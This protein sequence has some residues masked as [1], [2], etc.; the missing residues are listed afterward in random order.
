MPGKDLSLR[1]KCIKAKTC[2]AVWVDH[3]CRLVFRPKPFRGERVT[4][5]S[6]SGAIF[7]CH[8]RLRGEVWQVSLWITMSNIPM[9]GKHLDCLGV[10]VHWNST[11]AAAAQHEAQH[12]SC[13]P[14]ALL[15]GGV[16]VCSGGFHPSAWPPRHIGALAFAFLRPIPLVANT[17]VIF[18]VC[19]HCYAAAILLK[20]QS[21]SQFRRRETWRTCTTFSM[22]L[23]AVYLLVDCTYTSSLCTTSSLPLPHVA[24]CSFN[25]H[26]LF[27]SVV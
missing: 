20:S 22:N 17:L 1:L 16:A 12:I 18:N 7:P 27:L 25:M 3:V 13:T 10:R 26:L 23:S 4:D 6:V 24:A 11:A 21:V 9:L 15:C 19:V 5:F 14:P 8:R 2:R